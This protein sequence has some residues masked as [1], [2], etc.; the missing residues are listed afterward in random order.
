MKVFPQTFNW[1]RAN[2][3]RC[4]KYHPIEWL[5]RP[6]KNQ[7][8]DLADHPHLMLTA[9]WLK[10]QCAH[11]PHMPITLPPHNTEPRLL[12]N[13]GRNEPSSLKLLQSVLSRWMKK[14][15]NTC[16]FSSST[17]SFW[18]ASVVLWPPSRNRTQMASLKVLTH[19]QC[20]HYLCDKPYL[21]SE[22]R[23]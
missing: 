14:V 20:T 10:L 17:P 9:S 7:L 2:H 6:N 12:L 22:R 15:T 3:P 4:G 8:K 13:H 5:P 23:G 1:G 21:I 16:S 18:T 19:S 11:L